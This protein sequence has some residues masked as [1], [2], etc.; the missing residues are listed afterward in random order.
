MTKMMKNSKTDTRKP[1]RNLKICAGAAVVCHRP[2]GWT[3]RLQLEDVSQTGRKTDWLEKQLYC[4]ISYV[5][6]PVFYR[7]KWSN[8]DHPPQYLTDWSTASVGVSMLPRCKKQ[9]YCKISYVVTPVFYR[10]KWS[11]RDH[12][13]QYLTDWSTAPVGVS[14]LP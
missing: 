11:N 4:K 8:R 10:L 13:P 7:L 1:K 6:T 2:R 3:P 9:L 14:M 5:V 12:S